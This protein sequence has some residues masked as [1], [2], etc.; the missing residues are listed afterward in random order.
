MAGLHSSSRPT[1]SSRLLLLL[2]VL[3][4]TL[5]SF[6]FILQ[7]R[8]GL[9]DPVTRWSPDHHEFPGMGS[10]PPSHQTHSSTSDCVSLLGQRNSPAF[11]YYRDWKF[12]YVSDLK[13]KVSGI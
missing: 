7:W 1:S 9:N 2:T 11:P 10:S 6:A 8:G 5:A 13:P 4:L 12:D 3:P